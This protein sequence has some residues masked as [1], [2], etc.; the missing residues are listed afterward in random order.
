MSAELERYSDT[1]IERS[2]FVT[3]NQR[4]TLTFEVKT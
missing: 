2:T 4:A 1:S 3:L